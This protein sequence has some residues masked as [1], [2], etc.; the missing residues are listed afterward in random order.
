[1]AQ[2]HSPSPFLLRNGESGLL[3]SNRS[4]CSDNVKKRR[5]DFHFEEPIEGEVILKRVRVKGKFHLQQTALISEEVDP[6]DRPIHSKKS[7]EEM[8]QSERDSCEEQLALKER[9]MAKH[10]EH[11]RD[12]MAHAQHENRILK[13]AVNI[14]NSRCKDI[15]ARMKSFGLQIETATK[16]GKKMEQ[17]NYALNLKIQRMGSETDFHLL[18]RRPPDVF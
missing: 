6:L 14:Q 5:L 15:E 12:Q 1:M 3:A 11:F 8:V 2:V 4:F 7:F 13:R 18:E 16:H 10:A 9:E 17:Q